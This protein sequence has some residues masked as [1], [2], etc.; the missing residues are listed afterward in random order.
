[1]MNIDKVVHM[2]S[3]KKQFP[4]SIGFGKLLFSWLIG[5]IASRATGEYY[6]AVIVVPSIVTQSRPLRFNW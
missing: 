2:N 6:D 4:E 1:M 3:A 5:L